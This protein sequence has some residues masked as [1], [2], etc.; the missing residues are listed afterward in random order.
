MTAPLSAGRIAALTALAMLAFAANSVLNRLALA[1]TAIDAASFTLIR[2]AAGALVLWAL[3]R[4]QS[5]SRLAGD[6]P[7]ACALFVYAAAFSFAYRALPT[8]TGALLLFGTVQ[9]SMIAAGLFKG[10]RFRPLQIAGFVVALAGLAVLLAPGVSAPPV[11]AALLM[12]LAGLAWGVYSLR[13]RH[14]RA[15]P[16]AMTAGNFVRAVPL[17]IGLSMVSAADARID[18][19]GAG[20]AMLSG[21][22]ASGVGYAIWYSA[23]RGL[24][25]TQAATVQLSVPVIAALGGAL[26]LA[27]PL[28]ARLALASA[29]TLG[30]IALVV[31]SRR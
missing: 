9:V 13:G 17:A 18:L 5:G 26:L 7:G 12:M 1:D 27:E 16:L 2:L 19:A 8:G 23:L 29:A 21:A 3:V 20:Y 22:L 24:T 15:T 25:A 28:T 11:D 10:E 30:G 31:T 6:W 4:R 14:A